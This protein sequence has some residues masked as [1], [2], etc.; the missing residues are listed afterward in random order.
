MVSL[1]EFKI[2]HCILCAALTVEYTCDLILNNA[3]LC[4][5]RF[6]FQDAIFDKVFIL[7]VLL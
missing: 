4:A 2:S 1:C 7:E 5:L 3:N 6:Y